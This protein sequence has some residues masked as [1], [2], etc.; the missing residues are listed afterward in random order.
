MME[1]VEGKISSSDLK[2]RTSEKITIADFR[3][4][5]NR[6]IAELWLQSNIS[7]KSCRIAI[8]EVRPS[9]CQ[10]AIADSKKRCACYL[11]IYIDRDQFIANVP[12]GRTS[13]PAEW[14]PTL[15]PLTPCFPSPIKGR[16]RG[17][18]Q[19]WPPAPPS[20]WKSTGNSPDSL[21]PPLLRLPPLP[22]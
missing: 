1:I 18:L 13:P 17:R 15:A 5:Y 7:L 2:L 3:K 10:I 19:G 4:N 8:V 12:S 6:G 21:I 22:H 16:G 14:G 11:C 20:S 9:S